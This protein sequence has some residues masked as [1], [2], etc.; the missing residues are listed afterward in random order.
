[1]MTL[2]PADY[3]E[4]ADRLGDATDHAIRAVASQESRG[5]FVGSDG[6]IVRRFEPHHFPR[7]HWAALG[8]APG[9]VAPYK[10]ALRVKS[11]ARRRMA[12]IADAIDLE[13][14]ARASSWGAFQIMGFNA[15][16]CGYDS[17]LAMV[18]D[19]GLGARQQLLA[20]VAFCLSGGLDSAIR[21][22]DWKAFARGYNGDGA[23]EKYAAELES[24][25]RRI[26]GT[27]SPLVLRIGSRGDAVRDLQERLA[28]A[29]FYLQSVDG[30]FGA[31]TD[32]AVRAFQAARSLPVDGVVG[33]R[34]WAALADS[35]SSSG[36]SPPAQETAGERLARGLIEKASPAAVV[37]G[38]AAFLDK[39]GDNAELILVG[40]V[41][42][43]VVIVAGAWA[44][45][46]IRRARA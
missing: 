25:Y 29:G 31:G 24:K 36:S 39:L 33:A 27:A 15:G 7:Q 38:G 30:D 32:A 42:L 40:G 21:A 23:V 46:K 37:A 18:R 34:T 3:R 12:E 13:A 45:I 9:G 26:S 19:F 8:F 41:V 1:M 43:V 11:R 28:A 5:E 6:E 44:F 10:A 22:R 20:F 16:R 17:A 2:T 4:A 35:S 14:A